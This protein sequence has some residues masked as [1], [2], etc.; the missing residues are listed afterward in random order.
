M[1]DDVKAILPPAKYSSLNTKHTCMHLL[2]YYNEAGSV[3]NANPA[4][5]PQQTYLNI[6]IHIE[7]PLAFFHPSVMSDMCVIAM[8]LRIHC[9]TL[10]TSAGSTAFVS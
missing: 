5:N 6:T 2:N 7:Y 9:I 10:S 3:T 4:H 1:Y 8:V